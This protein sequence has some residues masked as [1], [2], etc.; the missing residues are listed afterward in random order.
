MEGEPKSPV[1]LTS[2]LT[3]SEVPHALTLRNS[4]KRVL[5]CQKIG[6]VVSKKLSIELINYLNQHFD[7]LYSLED[8]HN[9]AGLKEQDL[10]KLFPLTLKAFEM[11]VFMS[12]TMMALKNYDKIFDGCRNLRFSGYLLTEM[13]GMDVFV[14][15]PSH[16]VFETLM[17]GL[18]EISE[19]VET[20]IRRWTEM[21]SCM[22]NSD[23]SNLP[24]QSFLQIGG[25]NNVLL[26]NSLDFRLDINSNAS[27]ISTESI[28]QQWKG[29]YKESVQPLLHLMQN[30][31]VTPF[32]NLKFPT[33]A[34]EIR[35]PT[36]DESTI[37]N[38]NGKWVIVV[39]FNDYS[40]IVIIF[41]LSLTVTVCL[42][43]E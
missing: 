12:P 18:A 33:G 28:I 1:W 31:V 8:E 20:Y 25:E 29:L 4:L 40:S 2:A 16:K 15:Q 41:L 26:I 24:A 3:E 14:V 22:P 6:L 9:M 17:K 11:C 38:S 21:N 5:T 34:T 32:D 30:C 27:G 10:L 39:V 43:G 42:Y 36:L 13:T 37:D 23:T 7:Y 19:D 35:K